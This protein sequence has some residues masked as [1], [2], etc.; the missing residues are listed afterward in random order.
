LV[1]L[2]DKADRPVKGFSDGERQ[3]LGIGQAQVHY[4]DLLYLFVQELLMGI[5]PKLATIHPW[6]LVVPPDSS[7]APSVAAALMVGSQP[8]SYLPL[9]TTLGASV[10]FVALALWI[11]E[12]QEF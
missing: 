4:P 1:G 6:T 2:A 11:F 5:F 7:E 8:L 10:L 9:V 12:R 3:R